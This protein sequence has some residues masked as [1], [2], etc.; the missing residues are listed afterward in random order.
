M[1][2]IPTHKSISAASGTTSAE[3]SR[4]ESRLEPRKATIEFIRQFAR[5]YIPG[6][7]ATGAAAV[8]LN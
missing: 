4:A 5:C 3:S 8:I 1:I 6:P 7:I 2:D